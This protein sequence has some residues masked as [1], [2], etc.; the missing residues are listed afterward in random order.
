MQIIKQIELTI[1]DAENDID[2]IS[3]LLLFGEPGVGKTFLAEAVQ[4]IWNAQH[5]I[6]FQLYEDVEKEKIL[7]DINVP[8]LVEAMIHRETWKGSINDI[9]QNGVLYQAVE[10]SHKQKTVFI[11]DEIDK[12]DQEIDILLLDFIQNGR[13]SDP[14]FGVKYANRNNL[15][16]IMTSNEERELNKALPRRIR[17]VRMLYPTVDQ[18]F[19]IMKIK[20]PHIVKDMGKAKIENII[21]ISEAYRKQNPMIKSNPYSIYRALN[22]IH[23]LMETGTVEDVIEVFNMWFSH[24]ETDQKIILNL[25]FDKKGIKNFIKEN[26]LA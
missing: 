6:F 23:S 22:D 25:K 17:K 7:M 16:F 24:K 12:A 26:I 1:R 14:S 18:Q 11:L 3:T 9:I 10:S 21:K 4:T 19:K 13:I 20:S 2:G 8:K 5:K 15:I